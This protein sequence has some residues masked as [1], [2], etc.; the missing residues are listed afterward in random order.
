MLHLP[1][2]PRPAPGPRNVSCFPPCPLVHSTS[3]AGAWHV[4]GVRRGGRSMFSCDVSAWLP[5]F[6]AVRSQHGKGTTS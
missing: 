6:P 1:A 3:I 4:K 2:P 5:G